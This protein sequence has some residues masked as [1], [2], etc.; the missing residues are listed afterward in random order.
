MPTQSLNLSVVGVQNLTLV[1]N[2]GVAGSIDYDHADW[3]GAR[4]LA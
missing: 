3:A 4:L 2:N 1:A